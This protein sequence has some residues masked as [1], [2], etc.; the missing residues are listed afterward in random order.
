MR[1]TSSRKLF[2]AGASLTALTACSGAVT[3]GLRF[4]EIPEAICEQCP[5]GAAIPARVA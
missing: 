5:P 4:R 3:Q 2:L 1:D